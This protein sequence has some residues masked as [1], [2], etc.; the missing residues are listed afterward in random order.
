MDR[1]SL[2]I[3]EYPDAANAPDA[4]SSWGDATWQPP[5]I[6]IDRI[7]D[8][9]ITVGRP[10]GGGVGEAGRGHEQAIPDPYPSGSRFGGDCDPGA[11]PALSLVDAR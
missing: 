5:S 8:H 2:S 9:T 7:D 4:Q 11:G 6:Q 10:I 3:C 1:L